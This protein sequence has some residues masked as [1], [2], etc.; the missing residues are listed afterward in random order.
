MAVEGSGEKWEWGLFRGEETGLVRVEEW[1]L[2]LTFTKGGMR[3][4]SPARGWLLPAVP[5]P[6]TARTAWIPPGG[7]KWD[8][9]YSE[10]A[11]PGSVHLAEKNLLNQ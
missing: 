7:K 2:P 1:V 4:E 9:P 3:W 6:A 8:T 5:K 11:W 10:G